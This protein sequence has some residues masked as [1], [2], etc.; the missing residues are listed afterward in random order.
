[1]NRSSYRTK[2]NH[3]SKLLNVDDRKEQQHTFVS[4]GAEEEMEAPTKDGITQIGN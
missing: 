2:E 4:R 1:M 3:F